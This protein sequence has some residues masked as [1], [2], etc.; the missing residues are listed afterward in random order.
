MV[1]IFTI[2]ISVHENSYLIGKLPKI[3]CELTFNKPS[4]ATENENQNVNHSEDTQKHT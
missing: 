1:Y 3:E 4:N 2:F